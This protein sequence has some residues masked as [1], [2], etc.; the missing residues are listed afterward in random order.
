MSENWLTT[1][2]YVIFLADT[3]K[4]DKFTLII[5]HNKLTNYR[6][7]KN[8]FS[9][10]VFG[11]FILMTSNTF[12]Q[13]VSGNVT[14]NTGALPG[15]SVLIKGTTNGTQTDFDGN[16]KIDVINPNSILVYSYIFFI[17]WTPVV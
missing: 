13:S 1:M 12:S 7:M 15:V 17:P 4:I 14:S 2:D 8:K 5:I 11:M 10:I 16:Y 6:F 3:N 9:K